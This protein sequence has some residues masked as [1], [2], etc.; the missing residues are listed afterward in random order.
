MKVQFLNRV[1]AVSA[2]GFALHSGSALAAEYANVHLHVDVD[3]PADEVW[4]KVGGFCDIKDWLNL[5]CE[6]TSGSGDLGTVRS[7]TVPRVGTKIEEVM[8]AKTDHSYTYTQ[9]TTTILY[10]GTLEVVPAGKHKSRLNYSLVWD[11]APLPNAEA[12]A[13]DRDERTKRF[14]AALESMKKLVEGK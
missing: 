1:L 10:H 14:T 4:K 13:K 9:P 3:K 7:L 8:V 6:I 5:P 2:L 12:K 11:Q